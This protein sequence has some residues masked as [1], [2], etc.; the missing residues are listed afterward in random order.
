MELEDFVKHITRAKGVFL[1]KYNVPISNIQVIENNDE[2]IKF[3][4]EGTSQNG[5]N[6]TLIVSFKK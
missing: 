5:N 4:V 1:S 6:K 3:E 2:V